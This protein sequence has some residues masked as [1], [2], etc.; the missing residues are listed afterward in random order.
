MFSGLLQTNLKQFNGLLQPASVAHV[1]ETQCKPTAN[2]SEE[3]GSI[4]R[5]GR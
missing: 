1:T 5:V 2:V 3:P 4:P